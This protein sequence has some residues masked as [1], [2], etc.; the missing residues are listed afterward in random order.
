MKF[1]TLRSLDRRQILAISQ[2]GKMQG[3]WGNT[4]ALLVTLLFGLLTL[5]PAEA[6]GNSLLPDAEGLYADWLD[7]TYADS[8]LAAGSVTTVDGR[9]RSDW[10]EIRSARAAALQALLPRIQHQALAGADRRAVEIMLRTLA[11]APTAPATTTGDESADRC[12][13]ATDLSLQREP[14]SRA[15]YGCFEKF[16]N[17]I[18]FSGQVI[19]RSTALELLQELDN[20]EQRR[21]L[22]AALGPIWS[23]VNAADEVTSPYRRLI[24]L[25]AAENIR[26]G[27]SPITDAAR[28]LGIDA[29]VVEG[30][31]TRILYVWRAANPGEPLEP[32]DYWQHYASGVRLLDTRVPVSAIVPLCQRYYRDLGVDLA[33]LGVVFDLTPRRGKAP[34]AYAD[35]VRIGRMGPHGWRP[36]IARVSANVER[37]GLFIL[38]EII[39]ESGH[40]VQVSS[41]RTRP[42]FVGW[43]D[44]LFAE[45][46]ADVPSWSVAEPEWQE[47]YLGASVS[48]RA[49]L[50]AL[51]GNVM[52]DVA[53]G[54]FELRMLRG[55]DSDPNVVWTEITSRYLNV[56]PH[57]ELSWWALRV[58]LVDLPG[59]MINYGL[60]AILTADLRQRIRARNGP[61]DAGN[62]LWYRDTADHLLRFGVSVDTPTLLRKFLGRPASEQ[63]L[64]DQIGRLTAMP[65]RAS[66]SATP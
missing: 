66:V 8:T 33:A 59:Y 64:L 65:H 22:F 41:I 12:A 42:A 4:G 48:E 51:L 17:H 50:R 30:W 56:R 35:F 27:H 28:T 13:S 44:D 23:H 3:R 21:A 45:A 55:P 40:A 46:F 38:N 26:L 62:P 58:Q 63:P 54:L 5:R 61:F 18:E 36:A 29:T 7:A 57:P 16:G 53:W 11:N 37:G 14:L 60:G 47:R 43:G 34:L 6:A 20:T 32:W 24:R 52:L 1:E 49:G 25:S 19:T 39:H 15:L 10:Q 9:P 31:L 2:D